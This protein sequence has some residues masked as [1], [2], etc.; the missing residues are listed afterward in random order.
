M[1][2]NQWLQVDGEFYYFGD[3]GGMYANCF[4]PDGYWVDKS[5]AW[6]ETVPRKWK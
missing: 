4:T 3:K 5:G 2:A 6:D 1:A